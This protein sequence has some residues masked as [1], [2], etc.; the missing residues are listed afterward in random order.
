VCGK[1]KKAID[2]VSY[3]SK[4]VRVQRLINIRIAKA[5]H[6]VSNEAPCL[7]TG[8][9][10][11]A[12]K[13]DEASQ[14]YQLT[15]VGQKRKHWLIPCEYAIKYHYRTLCVLYHTSYKHNGKI[16]IKLSHTHTHTHTL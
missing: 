5:Y 11:I 13:I 12:I 8:L 6:T 9:T 10:P 15:K 1:K 4:L 16:S 2:K 14:F 3:K 7:L